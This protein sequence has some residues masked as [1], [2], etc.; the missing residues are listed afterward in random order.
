MS[1][2]NGT[3]NVPTAEQAPALQEAHVALDSEAVNG[4]IRLDER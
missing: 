3:L 4:K 1:P 2:K